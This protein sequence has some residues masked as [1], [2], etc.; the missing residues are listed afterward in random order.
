[1]I[2]TPMR[3]ITNEELIKKLWTLSHEVMYPSQ[4]QLV[5]EAIRRLDNKQK[6][7]EK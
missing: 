2:I 3:E 5:L 1:M 7:D 4:A 6:D